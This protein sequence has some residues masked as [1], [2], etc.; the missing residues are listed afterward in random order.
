[1]PCFSKYNIWHLWGRVMGTT[2]EKRKVRN[3]TK[4]SH[5]GKTHS[6]RNKN[7][8]MHL[9]LIIF[10]IIYL[11]ALWKWIFHG[12]I[13]TDIIH[14]GILEIK[15][16]SEGV[17]IREETQVKSPYEGIVIPKVQ[18]GERVPNNFD[19]AV[20]VDKDSKRILEEI[21]SLEINILRQFAESNPDSLG[22]NSE[23]NTII[24]QEVNKLTDIAMNSN[25][26]ALESVKATLERVINQR[27]REIFESSGD[28]LYLENEKNKL[29]LLKR[30]LSEN[31]QTVQSDFSGIV[32]WDNSV[33]NEKY[34]FNNMNELTIEDLTAEENKQNETRIVGYDEAFDVNKDQNFARL[35]NNQ[36]C[37]YVCAIDNKDSKKLKVGDS[38]S[39]KIEGINELIPCTVES[40][41]NFQDQD[42]CR[43]IVSFNRFIEKTVHLNNVE[44]QLIVESIEGLKIPQ[45]SLTNI[46]TFD[47]TADICLVRFNRVVIKR[48][49]IVANQDN[50]VIVDKVP[51][52]NETDP[53][54]VFDIYVVNPQNI[55]EGQVI[56]K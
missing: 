55:E 43:V 42:K 30:A 3:K 47:G 45:R 48:V 15:I 44:A 26:S 50:F 39:L 28:R 36:E 40:I 19:F 54:R 6:R 31:A 38:L 46:N 11:P 53:V 52:N 10:A 18:H 5:S 35:V 32:V 12:N 33:I 17:F 9:I 13:E 23:F 1:M 2:K 37:W 8:S 22:R 7:R 4:K 14:S 21:E 24:Q 51:D 49:K 20:V 16:P 29:E 56:D 34:N 27:N 41:E 25:F